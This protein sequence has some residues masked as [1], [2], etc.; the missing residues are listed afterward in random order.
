M[1]FALSP[2]R[3]PD[4][5]THLIVA[6]IAPSKGALSSEFSGYV[7]ALRKIEDSKVTTRR[8][9]QEILT[10]YEKARPA[11]KTNYFSPRRDADKVYRTQ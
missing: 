1:A 11:L 6:D 3:P 7:E 8:E 9:A 10:P 5:L 2:E 4:L